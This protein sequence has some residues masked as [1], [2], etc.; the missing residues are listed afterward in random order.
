M[1]LQP[2]ITTPLDL[3]HRQCQL[4][5]F[6]SPCRVYAPLA[7]AAIWV[8]KTP[9]SRDGVRVVPTT[10][11]LSSALSRSSSS[12]LL[13]A[14]TLSIVRSVAGKSD[15]ATLASTKLGYELRVLD[16]C[17]SSAKCHGGR[18]PSHYRAAPL[19][20]ADV[21]RTPLRQTTLWVLYAETVSTQTT[22]RSRE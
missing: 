7:F 1:R 20:P 6:N 2:L 4:E 13:V 16:E 18:T 10:S 12:A 22:S 21:R 19:S 3:Y 11:I 15:R 17:L 5:A 8:S 9:G 14:V